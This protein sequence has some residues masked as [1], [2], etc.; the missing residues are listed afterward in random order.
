LKEAIKKITK[1][2]PRF[3]TE[4]HNEAL[5]REILMEKVEQTIMEIPKGKSPGLDGFTTE[6]FHAC[7]YVIK[8]DSWEAIEDS[9]RYLMV[10]PSLH[11]M[12]LTLIPKEEKVEYPRKFIHVSLCNVIY[13]IISKVISNHLKLLL[14]LLISELQLGFVQGH[15]NLENIIL[16]Q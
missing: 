1:N 2:I 9:I 10:L 12:F 4:E 5:M 14:P 6:F 7:W 8:H 15:Q 13:K 11:S 3:I 16:V